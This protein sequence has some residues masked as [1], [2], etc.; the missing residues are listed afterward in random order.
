[1]TLTRILFFCHW[2]LLS[3]LTFGFEVPNLT[4]PVIDEVALLSPHV[5]RQISQVL[6]RLQKE[7]GV[8]IQVYITKSLQE[9][10]I[11]NVAI[12]I[13][14]QWKLG[15]EKTDKGLLFIIAPNEKKLRIEVGQGLEGDIPDVIAKR[16]IS[17]VVKPYFVKGEFNQGIL[18]GIQALQSYIENPD[19]TKEAIANES[20]KKINPLSGGVIAF[21]IIGIW[22]LLFFI[23]PTFALF[24]LYS[25]L[26]GGRGSGTWSG[27]GGGGSWSGGGGRSSGGGASG[28]W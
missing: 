12:Q 19:A 7:S 15:D 21:I 5:K 4:G 17:D 28:G 6:F 2:L 11:E 8:Q 26:R 23:N 10:P 24:L 25:I 18:Q 20:E 22:L 27:G 1:M 16:I 9:E 13:F 3:S 14:D